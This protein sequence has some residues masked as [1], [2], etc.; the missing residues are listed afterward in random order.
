LPPRWGTPKT[1]GVPAFQRLVVNGIHWALKRPVPEQL[2]R[3]NDHQRAVPGHV[4]IRIYRMKGLAG[5]CKND[6]DFELP[7]YLIVPFFNPRFK[8]KISHSITQHDNTNEKEH[9]GRAGALGVA[10]VLGLAFGLA[11]PGAAALKV[12]KKARIVLVGNNLGS[13]MLT[14]ATST[15]SCTCATPTAC[16][17]SATCATGATRRLPA[18]P[19]RKDPWA[20]PGAA[21]FYPDFAPYTDEPDTTAEDFWLKGPSEGFFE[22]EDQWLSRLKADVIIAFFGYN[23]SFAGPAGLDNYKAELDA[24]VKHT[25]GQKYNGA[26]APQ[27]ALVSPVRLRRPFRPA[28]P[29]RRQKGERQPETVHG[30]PCAKWPPATGCPSWMP[31]RPPNGGTPTARRRSPSTAASLPTPGTPGLPPC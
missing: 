1:S 13:R 22:T 18:P 14:S 3:Q 19:G 28:R 25:L 8:I 27:L 10:A 26:A 24:F 7:G 12:H 23:E 6:L 11:R 2:G 17:W 16:C 31:L 21:K 29:A 15:P 4:K 9:V 30:R 5:F 20:F